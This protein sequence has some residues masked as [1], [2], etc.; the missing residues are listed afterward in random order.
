MPIPDDQALTLPVLLALV[1]GCTAVQA[2]P[3]AFDLRSYKDSPIALISYAPAVFRAEG[4][5]RQFVT[6]KNVSDRVIAALVFQQTLADG[7][8][9][10]I[11]AIERVSVVFKPHDTKRLS[12]SVEET[13]NRVQRAART[14]V[15]VRNPV[16]SIVSVEFIDGSTWSAP[17]GQPGP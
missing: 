15:S 16:L 7:S 11:V 13:W 8:R 4:G 5:R 2:Q 12:V 17:L 6:V 10:E 9:R 3:V 1:F 14:G